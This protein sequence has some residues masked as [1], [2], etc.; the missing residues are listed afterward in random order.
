MSE[1]RRARITPSN[2]YPYS[3]RWVS[4]A[5]VGLTVVITSAKFTPAL[6]RLGRS[7][8]LKP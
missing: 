3:G 5:Y 7:Q 2:P 4:S 6:R 8:N 1:S